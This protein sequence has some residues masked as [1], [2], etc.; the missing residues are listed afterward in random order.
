M[1]THQREISARERETDGTS[2][3]SL[4][5]EDRHD[6]QGYSVRREGGTRPSGG[7]YIQGCRLLGSLCR[8][9]CKQFSRCECAGQPGGWLG[10]TRGISLPGS[11]LCIER[12][13]SCGCN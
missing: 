2:K 8:S 4:T 5:R 9:C 11:G 7:G 1:G 10:R 6:G 13:K 12:S 3:H